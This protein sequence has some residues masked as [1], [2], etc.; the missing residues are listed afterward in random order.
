MQSSPGQEIV[1]SLKQHH[2][3]TPSLGLPVPRGKRSL[4]L[5]RQQEGQAQQVGSWEGDHKDAIQLQDYG[6][7][8]GEVKQP[9]RGDREKDK[10]KE[11][12][13]ERNDGEMESPQVFVYDAVNDRYVK[14]SRQDGPG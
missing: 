10:E 8:D 12:E 4:D 5:S 7:A 6:A 3:K 11:K 14:E 13:K 9:H 2:M 1:E